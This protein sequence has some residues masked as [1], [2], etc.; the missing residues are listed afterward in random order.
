MRKKSCR[1]FDE[2]YGLK[3]IHKDCKV[4]FATLCIQRSHEE[5]QNGKRTKDRKR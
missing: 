2:I 4:D 1:R 3:A 5:K